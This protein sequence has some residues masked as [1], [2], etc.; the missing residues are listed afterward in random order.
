ME[1][2]AQKQQREYFLRKQMD[3]IRKELN[4][5]EG[6]VVEEYRTKIDEAGMPED[7]KRSGRPR[8]AQARVDG[9]L[10]R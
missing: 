6:S 4:E 3:S 2:G 8:A 1:S 9:R 7:V 10:L 5:D